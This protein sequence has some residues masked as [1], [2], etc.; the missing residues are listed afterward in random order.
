MYIRILATLLIMLISPYVQAD[1]AREI[2]D[3][4]DLVI[5]SSTESS[6]TIMQLATCKYG[7]KVRKVKCVEKPRIKKIEVVQVNVG[8]SKR[9]T[10][11]I[12]IILEPAS[13]RGIG[14]LTYTY[15]DAEK[16]T[17]SWLYLSALGRVKRLASGSSE[18]VEPTSLFGSEFTTEDME[19]GKLDEY[20]HE[21]LKEAK[22]AGR[23]VWIIQI[24]PKTRRLKKT[25]YSKKLVWVDQE[26]YLILKSQ[27]YDKK[28]K[29]Y[30]RMSTYKVEQ[31]QGAWMARTTVMMNLQTHRLTRMTMDTVMLNITVPDEFLAQRSLTDLAFRENQLNK[32]RQQM[33]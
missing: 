28:G 20:Q 19:T 9:D 18:D 3:K 21:I 17:Q 8:K 4:V 30:K 2:M 12:A 26:R 1:S 11:S 33:K 23:P 15:D 29:P 10:K 32:L 16:D 31:I 14:M 27:T 7:K 24:T 6:F 22:Y 25:R 13:E 5:R